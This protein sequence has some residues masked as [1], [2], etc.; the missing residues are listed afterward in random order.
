LQYNN[1]IRHTK[2]KNMLKYILKKYFTKTINKKI[3]ELNSEIQEISEG[4]TQQSK[5]EIFCRNNNI[6]FAVKQLNGLLT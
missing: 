1:E 2:P 3:A 5:A 6:E 4:K